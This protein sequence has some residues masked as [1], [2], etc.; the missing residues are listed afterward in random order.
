MPEQEEMF[1]PYPV[2]SAT[3]LHHP[4]T[5]VSLGIGGKAAQTVSQTTDSIQR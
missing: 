5:F 2:G 3:H 4:P 1:L